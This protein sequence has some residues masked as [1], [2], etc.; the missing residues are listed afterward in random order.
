[1]K[2]LV[3]GAC[4][5][6]GTLLVP[7][8]L[9]NHHQVIAIDTQWFGNYLKKHKNL[10]NI[11]KNIL[12]INKI[13]LEGVDTIIHLASIANDPMGDL[14]QNITWEYS[15]LGTMKLL[16]LAIEQNV[17]KI[18]YASSSS[19]YGLK[20]EKKVTE[21]LSLKPISIYNK[22]KM[23]TE[24]IIL[25]YSD[26]IDFTIIRPATVCGVSPRMRFDVSVNMMTY[27]A[28]KSG[29]MTVFG[30]N[31]TRPNI[32]MD[33]LLDL[34]IFFLKRGKKFNGIFNAGFENLKI[35]QIAKRVQK[36]IPSKIDIIK[37]NIDIRDYRVD[38]SKLLS[39]GY[40]PKKNI[41]HAINEILIKYKNNIN[42][43]DK[44]SFSIKWLKQNY[45]RFFNIT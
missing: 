34:Y 32:H 21:N 45:K 44:K 6:Q 22:A 11:K 43:V 35:I 40:K 5:Y 24:K 41:N 23:I 39:L 12:D 4:G 16:D 36:I 2:I 20:K 27:Q 37:N 29:K 3:T 25:S 7:M 10:K 26:K 30:G 13:D 14:V 31:Q 18:I 28:L 33:D 15:C 1:M 8:L 38:S 17:K 9:K 42:N 19:V